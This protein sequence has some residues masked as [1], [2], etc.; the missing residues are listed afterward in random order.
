MA[1]CA[2]LKELLDRKAVNY[3]VIT[4]PIAYTAQEIAEQ[5]HTSGTVVAKAVVL[6][7]NSWYAMAVLS[8]A[9]EIDLSQLKESLRAVS[10]K[11]AEER[12]LREIFADCEA[13][14]MPPFGNLYGLPVYFSTHLARAKEIYFNAGTHQE[15]V[16]MRVR[17]YLNLV[18]PVVLEFSAAEALVAHA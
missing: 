17:D 9:D 14:A 6:K 18:Q 7:V 12:E 11:L 13:G 15:V 3:E 4:H 16:R 10:V 8:A 1:I 2:K 5:M